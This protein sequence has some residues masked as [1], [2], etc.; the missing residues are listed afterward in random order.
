MD[1]L[2]DSQAAVSHELGSG[3]TGRVSQ[4]P[5][6]AADDDQMEYD[7]KSDG[8]L[9]DSET[10]CRDDLSVQPDQ[11]EATPLSSSTVASESVATLKQ[12]TAGQ[13]HEGPRGCTGDPGG[14]VQTSKG[15]PSLVPVEDQA[16]A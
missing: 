1:Q 5:N 14:G 12:S 11:A 16:K 9:E 6:T 7:S 8:E 10:N 13:T 15:P 3:A 4:P 2:V